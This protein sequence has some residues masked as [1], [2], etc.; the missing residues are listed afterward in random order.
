M[1]VRCT[2][3][4]VGEDLLRVD[5]FCVFHGVDAQVAEHNR[6]YWEDSRPPPPEIYPYV[7]RHGR[8]KVLRPEVK[9]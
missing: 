1:T 7:D 2:C 6:R 4:E 5:P 3:L 8:G 9:P